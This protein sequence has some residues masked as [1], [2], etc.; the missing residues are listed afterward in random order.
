MIPSLSLTS[1]SITGLGGAVFK[2]KSIEEVIEHMRPL[3]SLNTI[4]LFVDQPNETMCE[5]GAEF[6][7]RFDCW[8]MFD[9]LPDEKVVCQWLDAGFLKLAVHEKNQADLQRVRDYLPEQRL[10]EVKSTENL[11]V[12]DNQVVIDAKHMESLESYVDLFCSQLRTERDDGLW[13]TI[14]CDE[15]GVALGLVYSNRESIFQA[16]QR[17]KGVYWSRSR[18][19]LWEKGA[20]SGATSELIRIDSDCDSDALRFIVRQ[21]L[22]GFCHKNTR[23][24]FG[25]WRDLSS[26]QSWIKARSEDTSG[27][28]NRL[29]ND[30][31]LLESKLVE[32]AG[33]L[34]S[35]V[36]RD[37]VIWE[38][39]D[40]L[41]FSMVAM[42]RNGVDFYDVTQELKRRTG[43][44]I[45]RKGDAK[46]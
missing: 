33:E 11:S 21:Q 18:N 6:C 23:T 42:L 41:Y 2:L 46:E 13:P 44:L 37:E 38:A 32:E 22:P 40:V 43:Q 7:K 24:C 12:F 20:T 29:L 4:N 9:E 16:V 25:D 30:M 34:A 39:A 5:L 10:V 1:D 17:G 19:E 8:V 3:A 36:E 27:Y 31:E 15:Y 28:T 26:L 45:R 14:V 35:A